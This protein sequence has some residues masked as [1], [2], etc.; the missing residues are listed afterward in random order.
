MFLLFD[1]TFSKEPPNL[2]S[3]LFW[4]GQTVSIYI[5]NVKL[6]KKKLNSVDRILEKGGKGEPTLLRLYGN[7]ELRK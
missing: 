3:F 7:S 5:G 4:E 2:F 1:V 6:I